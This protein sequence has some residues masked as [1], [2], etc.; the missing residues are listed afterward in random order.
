MGS[1]FLCWRPWKRRKTFSEGLGP[2][3][4]KTGG[5]SLGE[6]KIHNYEACDPDSRVGPSIG[7]TPGVSRGRGPGAG[8]HP[9]VPGC[10][11]VRKAATLL[12]WP[13]RRGRRGAGLAAPAQL[14]GVGGGGG[15]CGAGS[16]CHRWGPA[17]RECW[18]REG[19]RARTWGPP[20]P[21]LEVWARCCGCCH[22]CC[23]F[24]ACSS[25]KGTWPVG[26]PA[27]PR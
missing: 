10:S 12:S 19:S 17:G 24:C 11:A 25:P 22:C 21:P 23:C 16:S 26:A 15:G 3:E 20:A 9:G 2:R 7:G 18:R 1:G 4:E 13:G 27:R 6:L 5:D 14:G 8:S